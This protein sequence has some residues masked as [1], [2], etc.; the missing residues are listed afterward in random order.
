MTPP[1]F[2]G[3]SAGAIASITIAIIL[4]CVI[5]AVILFVMLANPLEVSNNTTSLTQNSSKN[6]GAINSQKK[7]LPETTN[8]DGKTE[9]DSEEEDDQKDEV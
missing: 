8:T 2:P 4:G 6:T 9:S 3:L 1:P 7:S 5:I